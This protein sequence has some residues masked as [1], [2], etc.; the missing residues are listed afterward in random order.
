MKKCPYCAE[1]IQDEAIICRYCGRDLPILKPVPK[2][3]KNIQIVEQ[4]YSQLLE[5]LNQMDAKSK[6][7]YPLSADRRAFVIANIIE[8]IEKQVFDENS[9]RPLSGASMKT[10]AL[11]WR[12]SANPNDHSFFTNWHEIATTLLKIQENKDFPSE[13][14]WLS[15]VAYIMAKAMKLGFRPA[16]DLERIVDFIDSWKG[17]Q[18]AKRID[19]MIGSSLSLV[20]AMINIARSFSHEKLPKAGTFQWHVCRRAYAQLEATLLQQ[21]T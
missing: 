20:G 16:N 21:N 15:A 18:K 11:W 9:N 5:S 13:D 6:Q 14:E 12:L 1:L 17:I 8:N 4:K 7:N 2:S 3:Q 10:Y 19:R